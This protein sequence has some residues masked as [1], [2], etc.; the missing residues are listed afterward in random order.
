MIKFAKK[1]RIA[2]LAPILAG[3]VVTHAYALQRGAPVYPIGVDTLYP[4]DLPQIP[5]LFLFNYAL[6]Y[7]IDNVKNN[8]GDN[9]FGGFSGRVTGLGLRPVFVWDT[10]IF[11]ARPVT[12]FVLPIINESFKA[13]SINIPGGPTVPFGAVNRGKSLENIAGI[14]DISIGQILD[15]SLGRGIYTD[16]GFEA[17]LPNGNYNEN[18]F[19][20][21]ASTNYFTFSPNA[22]ITWRSPDNANDHLSLKIQYSVSTKNRQTTPGQ[23]PPG[24]DLANYQSGDFVTAEY[25]AGIGITKNLG[26]DLVGFALLQTTDDKQNGATLPGNSSKLFAIGPQIRYNIGPGAVAFKVEHEFGA[27]NS[28]EGNRIWL[29]I[30]F[31]LWIPKA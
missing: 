8:K 4:A 15:W 21:I 18:R 14:G 7:Q 9:L 13:S 11:G 3:A 24:I 29:Q 30:G 12:Y 31:P 6:D 2:A 22:A 28:P 20:N 26:L 27:Q 17:A 16:V 25:A 5:G 19:F 10:S 1:V 23:L